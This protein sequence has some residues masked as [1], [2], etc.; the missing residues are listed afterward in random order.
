[1]GRGGTLTYTC[2]HART[3]AE[4]QHGAFIGLL[5]FALK[6]G[7]QRKKTEAKPKRR[8]KRLDCRQ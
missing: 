5:F 6:K 7:K 4:K 3:H 1:M 2:M 8:E